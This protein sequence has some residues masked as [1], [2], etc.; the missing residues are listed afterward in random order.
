M[1]SKSDTMTFDVG[2]S[3]WHRYLHFLVR[4]LTYSSSSRGKL[5]DFGI[6]KW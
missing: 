2:I 5:G 1:P 3:R 6:V 4:F